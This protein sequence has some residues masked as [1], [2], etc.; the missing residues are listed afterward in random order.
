MAFRLCEVQTAK[1]TAATPLKAC[2][3]ARDLKADPDFGLTFRNTNWQ[4]G[5]LVAVSDA[6]VGN[7]NSDGSGDDP[8]TFSQNCYAVLLGGPKLVEGKRDTC[9]VLDFRSHKLQRV[10]RSSYGAET[11]GVEEALD[12]AELVRCLVAE[13]RGTDIMK[14]GGQFA[15]CSVPLT[16]ATD[17]KDTYDRVSKDRIWCTTIVGLDLGTTKAASSETTNVHQMDGHR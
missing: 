9:N 17:A 7:I 6:A 10:C 16:V 2:N 15:V 4:E 1:P 8:K 3:L 12:A 11:L 13:A 5:G 14:P